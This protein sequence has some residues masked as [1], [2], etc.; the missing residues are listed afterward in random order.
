MVSARKHNAA[1]DRSIRARRRDARLRMKEI[2]H[3]ITKLGAARQRL[4]R[5]TASECRKI[6][7]A[8]AGRR[9]VYGRKQRADNQTQCASD[10]AKAL[11][12]YGRRLSQLVDAFALHDAV[13]AT[14]TIPRTKAQQ[15]AQERVSEKWDYERQNIPPELLPLWDRVGR[16]SRFAKTPKAARWERFLEWAETDEGIDQTYQFAA[17]DAENYV[18]RMAAEYE[19]QAAVAA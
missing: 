9:G 19:R 1:I 13:L 15:L 10:R 14:Q 5:A 11:Q 2:R 7:A 17:E 12:Q 6:K 18:Q 16:Q 4:L 3:A 8:N